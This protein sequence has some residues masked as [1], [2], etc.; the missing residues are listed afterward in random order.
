MSSAVVRALLMRGLLAGVGAGVLA[1]AVAFLI[2]EPPLKEALVF[3]AAHSTDQ[4][5]ELVS[6]TVQSTAGLATAI[7]VFGAALGG[8]GALVF[9][10]AFGRIGRLGP[11]AT[12]A[13]V[14]A[15]GFVTVFLVP[16]LKYPANPP[17]VSDPDSL[18]Q[19][20]VWYVSLI[21]FSIVSGLAAIG[22]GRRLAARLGA[23]NATVV[24]A[25]VFVALCAVAMQILPAVNET[26]LDFSAAVMWRFRLA[27][28]GMQAALWAG[29]GLLFGY[30]A[31]RKLSNFAG[32]SKGM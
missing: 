32:I 2:G 28:V 30:L 29:F 5:M 24:A 25:A 31:A 11:Q 9:C 21:V 23:W 7:L 14:A 4:E 20:T 17:A 10:L 22:F 12:A 8:I 15:S 13:L 27:A 18:N 1:F 6:R 16:F 19:R 26:P 3:E